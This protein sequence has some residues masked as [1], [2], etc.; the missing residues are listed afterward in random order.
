MKI[1]TSKMLAAWAFVMVCAFAAGVANAQVTIPAGTVLSITGSSCPSGFTAYSAGAGRVV[2]GVGTLGSDT[3]ALGASGGSASIT[4]S[5]SQM[6]AHVHH[7][8]E[9]GT[10]SVQMKKP[11]A[12]SSSLTQGAGTQA[13]AT[14]ATETATAGS[15]AA[16]DIRQPYIALTQCVLDA[17]FTGGNDVTGELFVW[18][19]VI[20]AFA[21]GVIAGQQR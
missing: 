11:G 14:S 19:I 21:G 17:D 16:I 13:F 10:W 6:P 12:G 1:F 3:Y 15:G 18:A 8:E 9:S 20:L 7:Y 4:L 5:E 2:V